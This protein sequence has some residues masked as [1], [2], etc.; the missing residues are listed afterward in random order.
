MAKKQKKKQ[1]RMKK[2]KIG[3]SFTPFSMIRRVND[4]SKLEGK[5][6]R[7]PFEMQTHGLITAFE[8]L[9][10]RNSGEIDTSASSR[11]GL[12]PYLDQYVGVAG[13]ITDVRRTKD[14]VSLLI[15]DPSLVGT[16][17]NRKKSE[18][19]RLVKEAN[20]KDSKYFQD[21]PSQ[22][23][24][25]GHV[26]LF[27]P[28]VDASLFKE[29]ALYLGSVVT[30]Y[31]KVEL[32]K[33]RVS[34]SHSKKAPKYGLGSIILNTSYMPYMVQKMDES[35][36]K[37]ARSGRRIQ[38][39]FGNYRLG[40]VNDFD[41]RYAVALIE[42]SKLEPNVDWY[43]K[44]R[45]LGQKAHWNWIYNF[46]MDCDPEVERGLIKYTNFKPL[47]L[48]NKLT[49]PIELE[50]LR[51]RK[52]LRDTAVSEGLLADY[53]KLITEIDLFCNYSDCA[54]YL[55][56]NFGFTNIPMKDYI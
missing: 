5:A 49:L 54:D 56:S 33:G 21:I 42:G 13:R 11:I 26:W 17:G 25:S 44:I 7:T 24:F 19:K 6:E 47:M 27:L 52:S 2:S 29:K 55:E 9:N 50:V 38:M 12:Q 22:P 40:S 30:F 1:V 51:R 46:M 36:F 41:L 3:I 48:K 35:K 14:G 20:G 10:L 8:F 37:Q 28:E 31:A 16:F 34:T 18:V 23:I 4:L 45:G 53:D 15:L 32:Y 43:F 39:M